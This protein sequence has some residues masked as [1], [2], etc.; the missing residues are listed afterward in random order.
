MSFIEAAT[1]TVNCF[2]RSG[3]ELVN[4]KKRHWELLEALYYNRIGLREWSNWY[5]GSSDE[6]DWESDYLHSPGYLVDAF[7]ER[8]YPL[9]FT[10]SE[11]LTVEIAGGSSPF[12]DM[13]QGHKV[14]RLLLSLL[15]Q[16]QIQARTIEALTEWGIYGTV[17]GKVFWKNSPCGGRGYPVVQVVPIA[18][19]IPDSEN[20][21]NWGA[22]PLQVL[23]KSIR[24]IQET[25]NSFGVHYRRPIPDIKIRIRFAIAQIVE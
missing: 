3:L 11:Y 18:D 4:R 23:K 17:F 5:S 22:Y 21:R 12:L 15:D 10:G 20:D 16:G 24:R 1:E 8:I 19:V 9:I 7:V 6:F 13:N 2:C 14:G 25:H